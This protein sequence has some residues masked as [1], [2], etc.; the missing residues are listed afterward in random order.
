MRT[1]LI[2][3]VTLKVIVITRTKRKNKQMMMRKIYF[4]NSGP[5]C[6]KTMRKM[7]RIKRMLIR[8][9]NRRGKN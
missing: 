1:T 6:N 7:G 5:K 4:P 8:T 9:N 2:V 3:A